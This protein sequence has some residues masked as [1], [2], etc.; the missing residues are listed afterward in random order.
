MGHQD[1]EARGT[2]FLAWA[3]VTDYH[4]LGGLDN[5]HLSITGLEAEMPKIKVPIDLVSAE[6]PL[7]GLWMFLVASSL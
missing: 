2:A 1:S 7:P 6:R 5:K 3:T 4:P